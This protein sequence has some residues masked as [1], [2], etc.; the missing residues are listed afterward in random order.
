MKWVT[1]IEPIDD[2][3]QGYWQLR[4]WTDEAVIQTMS[5]INVPNQFS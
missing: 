4:G 2:E 1:E 5:R 3:F